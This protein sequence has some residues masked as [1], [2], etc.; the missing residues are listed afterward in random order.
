MT[1]QHPIA[2]LSLGLILGFAPLAGLALPAQA[3]PAQE[4]GRVPLPRVLKMLA[5]QYKGKQ[6]NTTMGESGGR[7][8]YLV[9]WQLPDGRIKVFTVD[10]QTGQVMG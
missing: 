8:V 6:L 3:G 4:Q 2:A 1:R 10:A 7:A 9:Q 5:E